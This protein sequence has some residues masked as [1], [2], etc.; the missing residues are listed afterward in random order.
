MRKKEDTTLWTVIS[1]ACVILSDICIVTEILT[2]INKNY[3]KQW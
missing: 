2:T 3:K 1:N